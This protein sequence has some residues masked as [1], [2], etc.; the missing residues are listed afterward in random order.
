MQNPIIKFLEIILP[1]LDYNWVS[2]NN[3]IN[4]QK[5]ESVKH[6]IK[7]SKV[8]CSNLEQ[9][10]PINALQQHDKKP[11]MDLNHLYAQKIYVK[12]YKE[13][14]DHNDICFKCSKPIKTT[15]MLFLTNSNCYYTERQQK[16]IVDEHGSLKFCS[17]GCRQQVMIVGWK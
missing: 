4:Y 13:N 2:S 15:Y 6:P 16:H 5:S 9:L 1:L 8:S 11:V 12:D 14:F 10:E 7:R 17:D 3:M